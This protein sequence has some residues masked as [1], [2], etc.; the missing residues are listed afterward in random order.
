MSVWCWSCSWMSSRC[1]RGVL[2]SFWCVVHYRC[3]FYL[4][5]I[6][7]SGLSFSSVLCLKRVSLCMC[8]ACFL[9]LA[10]PVMSTIVTSA[11]RI[12]SNSHPYPAP[13]LFRPLRLLMSVRLRHYFFF[14]S[15]VLACLRGVRTGRV[16]SPLSVPSLSLR[17]KWPCMLFRLIDPS[18][19]VYVN[20][21]ISMSSSFCS[22]GR[23]TFLLF[24][25]T[26]AAPRRLVVP[27]AV[28]FL[29][30]R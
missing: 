17:C 11:S 3:L 27:A 15:A 21:M 19:C 16:L 25:V 28:L 14:C 24:H 30:P 8:L 1:L 10:A 13:N 18:L 4:L 2:R 22:L 6:F 26:P 12:S 29:R 20:R 23:G 7:A 9:L 5:Y